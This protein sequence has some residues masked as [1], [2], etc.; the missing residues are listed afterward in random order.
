MHLFS[1]KPLISNH[2]M[3][4]SFT[5]SFDSGRMLT[6]IAWKHDNVSLVLALFQY[7]N[8][9]LPI[10][11]LPLKRRSQ[12]SLIFIIG[13]LIY[14]KTV[15]ILK[16]GPD[17]YILT[18]IANEFHD[19][20]L[21]ILNHWVTFCPYILYQT[22]KRHSCNMGPHFCHHCLCRCPGSSQF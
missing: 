10:Y 9:M 7:E 13:I 6:D 5:C 18:R 15:F 3:N 20:I 21:Q 17:S 4:A 2:L 8:T 1:T 12:H 22:Y 11:G 14:G 19:K 16:Q